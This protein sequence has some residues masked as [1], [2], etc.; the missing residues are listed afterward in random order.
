MRTYNLRECG[1]ASVCALREVFS[2]NVVI[3]NDIGRNELE[4]RR[5]CYC[6]AFFALEDAI[7]FIANFHLFARNLNQKCWV[8]PGH[9]HVT[10]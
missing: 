10:S 3:I 9:I 4:I 7:H 2:C 6:T 8:Y 1:R 5:Q